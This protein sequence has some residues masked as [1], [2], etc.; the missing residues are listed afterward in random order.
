MAKLK[1]LPRSGSKFW[2]GARTFKK[3]MGKAPPC[4]H[5]FEYSRGRE[6]VCKKCNIGYILRTERVKNGKIVI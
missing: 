6:V 4:E 1:N 3:E 2:D 5:F